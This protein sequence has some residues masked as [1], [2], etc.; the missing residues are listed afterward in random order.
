MLILLLQLP[1]TSI[2]GPRATATT[3][4]NQKE[5]KRRDKVMLLWEQQELGDGTKDEI[6]LQLEAFFRKE[7]YI[8]P[9]QCA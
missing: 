7:I 8:Y 2:G 5:K 6:A 3:T 9:Y 4:T 1:M